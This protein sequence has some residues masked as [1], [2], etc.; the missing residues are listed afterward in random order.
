[1][2][3]RIM[4]M[5]PI[6]AI[7]SLIALFS[8]EAA[9]V[10]DVIR[11]IYEAFVIY[12]F[13]QLLVG[14]MGGERSLLILLHGRPPKDAVFPFT[15]LRRELDLSDPHV[16]LFMKRGVLQYVQIKPILAIVTLILKALGKYNEGDLAARSGYLY[17]SIVYN[18]SI[19]LSLYCLAMFWMCISEDLKPFRPMP[20][21][22]CVKGIL[23]FSFWQSIGISILVAAGA[24]R[25]LGPYTDSERIAVGL[26]DTLICFEMPLFAIAHLYA[27]S[28]KDF[29]D[30]RASFVARMPI[31]FA[32]RDSFCIKDVVEDSKAT[33]RGEGMDYREF[34]PSEGFV[35]QG[36]GRERRIR[37]GLRYAEGG[38]KK[39]WLPS[40]VGAEPQGRLA[41]GL[42][43]DDEV[44][45]PLL[46]EQAESV[47]HIAPDLQSPV[48]EDPALLL[49][50]SNTAEGF[51][52]PFG[53]LDE[54]D[55]EL[56]QNSKKYLFGDYNYP[57][58]DASS[59]YARQLMW[60]EE[61][62]VL[63][64]EHSAYYTPI[65]GPR[66]IPG[67][68]YGA[69][70]QTP[71]SVKAKSPDIERVIDHDLPPDDSHGG[72]RLGWT[73]HLPGN[74]S[75]RSVP[76]IRIRQESANNSTPSSSSS[77]IPSATSSRR[78]KKGTP[79]VKDRIL[80]PDAV[81]L[82]VEDDAAAERATKDRKSGAPG[83]P[84]RKVY[85]RGY[86][87]KDEEGSDK[88]G[89]FEIERDP[90]LVD[91]ETSR[92]GESGGVEVNAE[93]GDRMVV[94]ETEVPPHIQ[95]MFGSPDDDENPWA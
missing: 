91:L 76:Q 13:F 7:A 27:F 22:L 4:L 9:F 41:R 93:G 6:Y 34:E 23:F 19:C 65:S 14:Y 39:Y 35:H 82:I 88:R 68:S 44:H 79:P 74:P 71:V 54:A 21:F 12:C 77:S 84:L 2:V 85:R 67:P 18:F 31:K 32:I 29:V 51:D 25:H 66:R 45:A 69:V 60:E 43:R 11:D 3:I 33:L 24:I 26:T 86:V 47:F 53:D 64:D 80:P 8:L 62:R 17:V 90:P 10:I 81:D 52:L 49:G 73:K 92:D 72:V 78:P 57:V 61:E 59:E 95:G 28:F 55:E 1:M 58:I 40:Q 37:A 36:T 70:S 16:F 42:N 63:R 15:L 5:V 20:K 87:A 56:F 89:E 50:V 46:E 83:P 38:R 94:V 48:Q 30:P 75:Q